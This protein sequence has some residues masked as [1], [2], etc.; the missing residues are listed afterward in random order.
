MQHNGLSVTGHFHVAVGFLFHEAE[1][2]KQS[3]N[4]VPP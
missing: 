3:V 4:F 1:L 2:A